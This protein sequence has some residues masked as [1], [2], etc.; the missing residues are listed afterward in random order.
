M[1]HYVCRPVTEIPKHLMANVRV[2]EGI[3]LTAGE[4]VVPEVIGNR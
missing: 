2:N 3:D 1:K 4:A